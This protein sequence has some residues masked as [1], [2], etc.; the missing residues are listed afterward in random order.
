VINTFVKNQS[1]RK[2][3]RS[4]DDIINTIN[5][6]QKNSNSNRAKMGLDP[7]KTLAIE[8]RPVINEYVSYYRK[9]EKFKSFY[10]FFNNEKNEL[11]SV[12]YSDLREPFP[13]KYQ[14]SELKIINVKKNFNEKEEKIE[15]KTIN[16]L[17]LKN[18]K[19]YISEV[20]GKK[21][22]IPSVCLVHISYFIEYS[23]FKNE[24][25]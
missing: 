18:K 10:N 19:K 24:I 23:L 8:H 25:F 3:L 2:Q 11:F 13:I 22:R 14:D 15:N 4:T 7:I 21:E 6:G 16:F 17:Q 12:I 20:L 1:L 5:E 9:I